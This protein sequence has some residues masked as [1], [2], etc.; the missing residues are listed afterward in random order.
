LARRRLA[1][2]ADLANDV[3]DSVRRARSRPPPKAEKAGADEI[4]RR[5]D[6]TRSRL[7]D[8][9]PPRQD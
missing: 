9:I 4:K 1:F 5:L 8:Q 6:E 2:L 3:R 7:R